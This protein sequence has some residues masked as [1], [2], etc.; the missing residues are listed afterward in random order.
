MKIPSGNITTRLPF[1]AVDEDDKITP[2]TGLADFIV[3]RNRNGAGSVLM[4]NPSVVEGDATNSP[5]EYW[6]LVDEDTE[7]EAGVMEHAMTFTITATGMYTARLACEITN[8]P[9]RLPDELDS[10]FLKT[11]V[12]RVGLT[13][14]GPGG[15][16]GQQ[17]GG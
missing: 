17:Y 16:G 1:I 13:T 8:L 6:L 2:L 9:N 15:A 10:G 12:K 5:G 4:D 3:Y 7:L 11:S 14:I